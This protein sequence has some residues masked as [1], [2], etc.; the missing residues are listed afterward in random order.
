M[1]LDGR[2]VAQN[3]WFVVRTLLPGEGDG[4][5]RRVVRPSPHHRGL[6]AR[7]GH[8]LLAGRLPP[9]AEEGRGDR[10][11]PERHAPRRRRRVFEVT[12]DGRDRRAAEGEG[13]AAGARTS[14][15]TTRPFDFSAVQRTGLYFIQYGEQ[16]TR[17]LPH[18]PAGVRGHLAPD[19]GRVVP[20]ADGPHVRERGLPGLARRSRTWTTRARRRSNTSTSTAT[21][22]GRPPT[23]RT[24]RASTS[25][26]STSAAGSTRATTTSGRSRTPAPSCTW[27]TPGSS[28]GPTRD[29]TLVD[30]AGA[31]RRHPPS[32]RQAGPPAADRARR[33]AARRAAPGVRPGDPRAS[34]SRSFTSTTTSATARPRRTACIYDP[35][36]APYESNGQGSGTPDDRWAFTNKS[37]ATNYASSA[38]LAA[39]SRAL[40]GY[41]DALAAECL[42]AAKKAWND[43]RAGVSRRGR[44]GLGGDV[45]PGRR[46]D[47]RPCSC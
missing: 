11:G 41:D 29:E 16:R 3:G 32:G 25:P 18:R 22:W 28:S 38:A 7:P 17:D 6:E 14:A 47:G 42:A 33:A 9:R 39:A 31:L 4:Q 46:A 1:L 19:P 40:R 13:R 27:W 35:A 8:R 44:H 45:P 30:Q 12:A 10:A 2:N 20:G 34:S 15:T 36:L 43:E 24:R 23:R 5:G 21:G 37:A 26:A